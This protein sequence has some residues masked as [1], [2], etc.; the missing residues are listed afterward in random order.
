MRIL[1]LGDTHFSYRKPSS[2]C[3][4]SYF[5][6]T[7]LGKLKQVI[8]IFI[9]EKCDFIIQTGDW[10]DSPSVSLYVIAQIER[11]LL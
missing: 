2:R 1:A 4:E 3:D 11:L 5:D 10:F 7:Q 9:R 6:G 8:K